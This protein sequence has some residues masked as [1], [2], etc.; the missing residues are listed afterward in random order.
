MTQDVSK[1]LHRGLPL[2]EGRLEYTRRAFHMLPKMDR[3]RILDV[4]CGRG[5]PT[6]ELARL[7]GGHVTGVDIDQISLDEL[8]RS[9]NEEGLSERVKA[10]WTFGS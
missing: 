5:D 7:S 4:G 2:K 6:L 10:G 9:A 3:P 8:T 1:E